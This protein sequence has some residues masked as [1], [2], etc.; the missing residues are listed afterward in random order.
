[1]ANIAI[2]IQGLTKSFGATRA[3]ADANLSVNVGESRA[4]LG[5]NGAGKST[6]IG[7]LAG[8]VSPDGGSVRVLDRA[9]EYVGA[10]ADSIACVFQKSTLVP[11]LTV[12]ENISLGDYPTRLGLVDHKAMIAGAAKVLT[13]WGC[14]E[15]A[16]RQ[17]ST[18]EPLQRK[19]VEV[20]RA[21]A[22]GPKILLLDE[23]TAGLDAGSAAQL[24]AQ[25]ASARERGVTVLYVSHHLAEVF[26]VCDSVTVLR[27]GRDVARGAITEFTF[28]GIVNAMSGALVSDS[29]PQ[30]RP[31]A[32]PRR[33]ERARESHTVA[34]SV[35][36]LEIDD[37][38]RGASFAVR[39]GESV[40][41]TGLD[42]AG[43]V[44]VAQAIAGELE[45]SSG[46][47]TIDGK[48]MRSGDI[49]ASIRA[50]VGTVPEDR[51]TNGFVP[52]LS[53]EENATLSIIDRLRGRTG[54]LDRLRRRR[55]FDE[56]SSTW[57][58]KCSGP[59]QEVGELSGGNQQKVVLARALASSPKTLVV[60]NPT[61]GVDV[62]AKDSIYD[63]LIKLQA[64]GTS[65]VVVSSDDDDLAICDRVLVMYK[66]AICAELLA[67]YEE[68]DLVAAVQGTPRHHDPA[69]Q[70]HD[71]SADSI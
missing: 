54:L 51:H 69:E 60:I 28:G 4:L 57:E 29:G 10:G 48:T 3:L 65:L 37:R 15:L 53:V 63:S 49:L 5:R 19:V 8:T 24:F 52:K 36:D 20:C 66:G 38:V 16:S 33:Q 55:Q 56:L 30:P 50:G 70:T 58:I 59:T 13:D 26:E 40:G 43:H 64:G 61:A 71:E 44:Q 68:R 11:E 39:S 31:A 7:V 62:T 42:G 18:L 67:G 34:L 45:V 46:I 25:I 32:A 22:K 35:K 9:G 23:P 17:V 2:D 47:L 27:D 12:A 41:L 21:L 14:E 1:M 6:L